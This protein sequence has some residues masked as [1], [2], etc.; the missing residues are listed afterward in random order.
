M[1]D[2]QAIRPLAG[3]KSFDDVLVT[4]HAPSAVIFFWHLRP[5]DNDDFRNR[6]MG[7]EPKSLKSTKVGENWPP[8]SVFQGFGKS[9]IH[10]FRPKNPRES[11]RK[12]FHNLPNINRRGA[13]PSEASQD[14][15]PYPCGLRAF[16]W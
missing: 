7:P 4:R 2:T 15:A 3:L 14:G 1:P 12:Q 5:R 16:A 10:Q 9:A 6:K 8:E 11:E 13:A